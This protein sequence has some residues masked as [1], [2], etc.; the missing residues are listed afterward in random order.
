[1]KPVGARNPGMTRVRSWLSWALVCGEKGSAL[2]EDCWV[3]WWLRLRRLQAQGL[4]FPCLGTQSQV[5]APWGLT[6][7][8]SLCWMA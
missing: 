1:M 3:H 2:P 4:R 8:G 5:E 7:I 6:A